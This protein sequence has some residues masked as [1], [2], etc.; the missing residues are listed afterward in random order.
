M[1]TIPALGLMRACYLAST[2]AVAVAAAEEG[3][4]DGIIRNNE[5]STT[6]VEP[7]LAPTV[8]NFDE[9]EETHSFD[10]ITAVALNA[11]LIVCVM[12]AYYVKKHK[13]YYLP[14]SAAAM[15]VGV[16][17]GGVARLFLTDLT[18]WTFSP[19]LFFF[20]L[21]PPIIFEAGYSLNK[22]RFIDNIV[23][24]YM[25]L[26]SLFRLLEQLNR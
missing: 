17:I 25:V 24:R 20:V 10:A 2:M 3:E 5:T 7:T 18:L 1:A 4:G 6:T 15:L 9:A 21:L 14:E 8:L 16:V 26:L 22:K 11:T 19:E 12:L 23:S 13:I